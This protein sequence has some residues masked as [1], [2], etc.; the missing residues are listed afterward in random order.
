MQK[1][2]ASEQKRAHEEVNK[3]EYDFYTC[4]KCGRLI[5]RVEEIMAFIPGTK[6][7]GKICKCGSMRY[8]PS[9]L[10]WWGWFLPRVWYFAYLRIRGVV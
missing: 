10:P 1:L 6:N 5:T 8:R 9:N 7:S 2:S 3:D 4:Y